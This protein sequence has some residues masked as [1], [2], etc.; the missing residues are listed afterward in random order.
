ML[1]PF[2]GHTVNALPNKRRYIG[3]SDP[4]GRAPFRTRFLM[5][6]SMRA[7]SGIQQTQVIFA[8]EAPMPTPRIMAAPPIALPNGTRPLRPAAMTGFCKSPTTPRP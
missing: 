8:S 6:Y 4:R 7:S 1:G 3:R 2:L 5:E